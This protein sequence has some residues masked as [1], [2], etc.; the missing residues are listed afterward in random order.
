MFYQYTDKENQ[1]FQKKKNVIALKD[2]IKLQTFQ[3]CNQNFCS[4]SRNLVK[5]QTIK[6]LNFSKY[7]YYSHV[8]TYTLFTF[9]C[10]SYTVS[11]TFNIIF[12]SCITDP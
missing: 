5:K 3:N 11:F 12:I 4:C 7:N 1:N 8:Y 9:K 6:S 10:V 2:F